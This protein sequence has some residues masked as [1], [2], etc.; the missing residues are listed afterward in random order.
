VGC[1]RNLHTCPTKLQ[2]HPSDTRRKNEK[3]LLGDE[4]S[5]KKYYFSILVQPCAEKNHFVFFPARKGFSPSVLLS[6]VRICCHLLVSCSFTTRNAFQSQ[7]EFRYIRV[8][9]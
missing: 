4:D 2:G 3:A 6:R 1:G 5:E 9:Q 7:K 8:Y